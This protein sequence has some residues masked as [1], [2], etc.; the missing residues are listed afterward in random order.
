[1]TYEQIETFLSVV[2]YGNITAAANYLYVSQSTVSN[3]LQQLEMELGTPL[4]HRN[5]GHRNIELTH[6][7]EAFVGIASQWAALYK[8][9]QNLKS[10]PNISTIRIAS[11]DAVNNYT[12]VPF[13]QEHL[14]RY[15]HI[16]LAIHTHHSNEIYGL[17]QNRLADIGFVFTRINYSDII[18]VPIYRELMYLI[19]HKDSG[20]H[21][22]MKCESLNPEEEI[23]LQWGQDYK[24]WHNYNWS[25][26][27]YPLITVNTGS[28]LQ[29]YLNKPGRWAV[30]PKTVI[31]AAICSNPNLTY[32]TL[33][34]PPTPRICY[35]VRN[36]YS[37]VVH[38]AAIETLENELDRFI[39]ENEHICAFE[40]WMLSEV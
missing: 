36:R 6:Y 23:Y 19:C 5:K 12:F 38:N 29:R 40:P 1:M 33:N 14:E 18:T 27:R 25:P 10:K 15:P 30:A 37:G 20:Y 26:E 16:K 8:E 31:N 21:D 22:N 3:R 17:V 35:E 4:L 9:T 39:R 28:M 32:Y 7:G 24:Q 34:T 13:F 2:I 11:V